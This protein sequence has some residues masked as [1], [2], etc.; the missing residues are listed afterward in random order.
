[1]DRIL[2]VDTT[3]GAVSIE[4]DQLSGAI[5]VAPGPVP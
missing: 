3:R 1:M 2:A 4:L 5:A